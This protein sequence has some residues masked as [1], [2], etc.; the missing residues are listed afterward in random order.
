[1]DLAIY[2]LNKTSTY[3]TKDTYI[4]LPDEKNVWISA[5]IISI[6][7]NNNF[8]LKFEDGR[9][10]S[11]KFD[12]ANP[13]QLKN[14]DIFKSEDDLTSLSFL[15]EASVLDTL[16][17]RFCLHKKIYTYCGIVLVA[18]NPYQDIPSLYSDE[19]ITI[20]KYSYQSSSQCK[21]SLDPH[22]FAV[23]QNCLTQLS[24][25]DKDQSIIIS[26]ESG[27]GKT[28]T[29]KYVMRYLANTYS[30]AFNSNSLSINPANFYRGDSRKYVN[31]PSKNKKTTECEE[32]DED[33][34][35]EKQ[36]LS[37]NP[38]MEALGNAKTLRN[39]NSSRFGKYLQIY[40]SPRSY[41]NMNSKSLDHKRPKLDVTGQDLNKARDDDSFEGV[42]ISGAKMKTYLLEKSRVI[43]QA[44]GERNFHI[45]Y[46]LCSLYPAK[47][48]DGATVRGPNW[49]M[50][51]DIL[52]ELK[53]G[54]SKM[55]KY[56]N[57]GRSANIQGVN[58]CSMF[59]ETTKAFTLMGFKKEVQCDIF[60]ILAAILHLGNLDM[61]NLC[62][63]ATQTFSISN[64]K[65]FDSTGRKVIMNTDD[66]NLNEKNLVDALNTI[67]SLLGGI[68]V[69]ELIKSLCIRRIEA[70]GGPG[71]NV[72]QRDAREV[73]YSFSTSSKAEGV[74]DSFSKDLY[75]KMFNLVVKFINEELS[76]KNEGAE[77]LWKGKAYERSEESFENTQ[78]NVYCRSDKYAEN[79]TDS[80]YSSLKSN[81]RPEYTDSLSRML[82]DH[83]KFIGLLDIYGFEKFDRNNFEQLCINY[84]NEKL[85]QHFNGHIFKLEQ[86][87]Y[88]AEGLQ[89]TLVQ[90]RDNQA[91]IDLIEG[92]LG[93]L[94]LLNEECMVPNGSDEGFCQKLYKQHNVN[95]PSKKFIDNSNNNFFKK[96]KFGEV[97]F[98]VC[99]SCED[100]EYNVNG[101]CNKNQDKFSTMDDLTIANLFNNSKN[102]VVD[103]MFKPE[104]LNGTDINTGITYN[105]TLK[106]NSQAKYKLTV[107]S[108][109]RDSLKDLMLILKA[110]S[111]HYVRCI[112]TN[113]HKS[114]FDLDARRTVQQ[115]RACG[116][117]ET[118]KISAAGYP[119]RWSLGD[120]Y[121]R[122]HVL[123]TSKE[124]KKMDQKEA[125]LYILQ[126]IFLDEKDQKKNGLDDD[127]SAKYKMGKTKVFFRSNCVA[128]LER[129]LHI[130]KTEAVTCLQKN[131]RAFCQR[132]RYRLI[133]HTVQLLQRMARGYLARKKF[134]E[135]KRCKCVT[136]I[137][138]A[139]RCYAT[140][141]SF[142]KRKRCAI[143][144]QSYIRRYLAWKLFIKL[145]KHKWSVIV[146]KQYR[147]WI[148]RKK[149]LATC[150]AVLLIQC[151]YRRFVARRELKKLKAEAS[152]I[153]FQRNMNKGLENK[154]IQLQ[155]KLDNEVKNFRSLE[156]NYRKSQTTVI[157]FET[158]NLTL[159]IQLKDT[160][161]D[162]ETLT[163]SYND[164]IKVNMDQNILKRD[165]SFNSA[166]IQT[167][168]NMNDLESILKHQTFTVNTPSTKMK[169]T[170]TS[171]IHRGHLNFDS[172]Y[173]IL[174][175][176]IK[177]AVEPVDQEGMSIGKTLK[178]MDLLF[179]TFFEKLNPFDLISPIDSGQINRENPEDDIDSN[180]SWLL[181]ARVFIMCL[182]HCDACRCESKTEEFMQTLLLRIKS[183]VHTNHDLSYKV[184]WLANMHE[185]YDLLRFF[186]PFEGDDIDHE[187][188]EKFANLDFARFFQPV[189]ECIEDLY[190]S[191]IY[192]IIN[193]LS[194]LIIPAILENSI[195]NSHY[196]S[197][198]H[199]LNLSVDSSDANKSRSKDDVP[200]KILIKQL[201]ESCAIFE[202]LKLNRELVIQI[203][204]QIFYM[205]GAMVFNVILQNK[206]YCNFT[207]ATQIRYNLSQL[208]TFCRNNSLLC[209]G[210]IISGLEPLMAASRMI[211]SRKT[212]DDCE[213]LCNISESL[214]PCQII[215]L[216][217][218]YTPTEEY[219]QRVTPELIDACK[220]RL[221]LSSLPLKINSK[222]HNNQSSSG[223]LMGRMFKTL[224]FNSSASASLVNNNPA[225]TLHNRKSHSILTESFNLDVVVATNDSESNNNKERRKGS[226]KDDLYCDIYHFHPLNLPLCSDSNDSQK[227]ILKVGLE[228]LRIPDQLL[229]MRF[230]QT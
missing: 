51:K 217:V 226:V 176:Q 60:R 123:V 58:D 12:A 120:F 29:A 144:I 67:C 197:G 88:I 211:Q 124:I 159:K 92:R 147:M 95:N 59:L 213:S 101:F 111:P 30:N 77:N 9:E 135:L 172:C 148:C 174:N 141:K 66:T 180:G 195:M 41:S 99:H 56:L 5:M 131:I 126:K 207:K 204:K 136:K 189:Y 115:L 117:L 223:G 122:Y 187:E 94:D 27:A 170:E 183:V 3:F 85:Q 127:K 105:G 177:L 38:I 45:F 61:V 150:A 224:F 199:K 142:L 196:R 230:A 40:F 6:G 17:T 121:K 138:A 96:P 112:K 44:D 47:E 165:N 91:C 82:S 137:Q 158:Q 108:Q 20:Y 168:M 109:F 151:C 202:R 139:W 116:I 31:A 219:E 26:G 75:L 169:S 49:F 18:L 34:C 74:R 103:E 164:L 84:A 194:Q 10:K 43:S 13:P 205:I 167:E 225:D 53:L 79:G 107:S 188:C 222:F 128:F 68:N 119:S 113:D 149:F 36:A 152:T 23:A 15:N 214:R 1:M 25:F 106:K 4:W 146:Q 134:V 171:E 70:G 186:S 175:N 125:S 76:H 192:N 52:L 73:I 160:L 11:V 104:A 163:K 130:R 8:M 118:I 182:R 35:I 156:E 193:K 114:P 87:E 155:I 2:D 24:K 62:K 140:R 154:I 42:K 161:R 7:I 201:E 63:Y 64:A 153:T 220:I 46:Q 210:N 22:I 132:T 157:N 184:F 212:L 93:I 54:P 86:Q 78:D 133:L 83:R 39:D 100:I 218:S 181:P 191:I 203:F 50:G 208:E 162:L 57:Y 200:L 33:F 89:W 228:N 80:A 48:N 206:N 215:H 198:I 229:G 72:G 55:F 81:R 185:F 69:D 129:C 16:K 166:S 19:A 28:M 97:S 221:S 65:R 98:I 32:N 143:T 179:Y 209:K 216:L 102:F 190:R 145:Q 173:Q 71:G 110:S 178:G 21:T 90:F 227:R 37:S 14:P